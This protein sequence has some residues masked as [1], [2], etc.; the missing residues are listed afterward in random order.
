M[1]RSAACPAGGGCS[2]QCRLS[3]GKIFSRLNRGLSSARQFG[4]NSNFPRV[5]CSASQSAFSHSVETLGGTKIHSH[6]HSQQAKTLC[7]V[8]KT[9]LLRFQNP[10]SGTASVL[11]SV[12]AAIANDD[13]VDGRPW[14]ELSPSMANGPNSPGV[15]GWHSLALGIL[16]WLW[17][18]LLLRFSR[19]TV[20]PS[21]GVVITVFSREVDKVLWFVNEICMQSLKCEVYNLKYYLFET[22]GDPENKVQKVKWNSYTFE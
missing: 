18:A 13:V 2:V 9:G 1:F 17:E 4:G 12:Q 11:F 14:P 22:H 8:A 15:R 3:G 7:N 16:S 21:A 6:K 19:P 5:T 10:P 20:R